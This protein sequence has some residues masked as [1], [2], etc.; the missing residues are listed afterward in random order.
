MAAVNRP[1]GHAPGAATVAPS[2]SGRQVRERPFHLRGFIVFI[3]ALTALVLLVSGI[4]LFIAPSSRIARA[5]H[6]T[7]LAL[8]RE[9]WVNLHNLAA[10]LFVAGLI[11]HIT[12]NWKPLSNYVISRATHHW[13]LKREMLAAVLIV[14]V[15]IG[16]VAQNLPPADLLSDLSNYF[17]QEFWRSP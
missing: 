17:R 16:L 6:W 11:W 3:I 12:F 7:L 2:A 8:D 15:L 1:P 5:I 4:V 10:I 13:N 9:A 14:V